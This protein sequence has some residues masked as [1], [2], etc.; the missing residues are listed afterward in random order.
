[1][2]SY[3]GHLNFGGPTVCVSRGWGCGSGV[4]RRR[5]HFRRMDGQTIVMM[6]SALRVANWPRGGAHVAKPSKITVAAAVSSLV[7]VVVVAALDDVDQVSGSVVRAR[8]LITASSVGRS[9]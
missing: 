3:G 2:Q 6:M 4:G 8:A 5:S 7:V 1:M 9:V